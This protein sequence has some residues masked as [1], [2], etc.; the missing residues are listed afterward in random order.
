MT[1]GEFAELHVASIVRDDSQ[2]TMAGLQTEVRIRY[3]SE[4]V[5]A[6]L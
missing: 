4:I 6:G 2:G 1:G 5:S 3:L